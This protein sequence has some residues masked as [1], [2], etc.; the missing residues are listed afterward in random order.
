M[1]ICSET[2]VRQVSAPKTSG[3]ERKHE[4]QKRRESPLPRSSDENGFGPA[5]CHCQLSGLM[6]HFSAYNLPFLMSNSKPLLHDSNNKKNVV[7]FSILS[8][9][10]NEFVANNKL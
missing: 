3:G 4:K 9:L 5:W 10:Q 8:P 1:F 2:R 6:D 7:I